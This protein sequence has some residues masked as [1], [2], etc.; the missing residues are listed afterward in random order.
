LVVLEFKRLRW[1]SLLRS[2]DPVVVVLMLVMAERSS[3]TPD[4]IQNLLDRFLPRLT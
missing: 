3:L 2:P 1:T 4:E